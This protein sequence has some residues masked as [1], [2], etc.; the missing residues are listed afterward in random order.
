M[1]LRFLL[2]WGV[3]DEALFFARGFINVLSVMVIG[4]AYQSA[5]LNGFIKSIGDVFFVLK[6]ESFFVFCVIIPASLLAANLGAS[7]FLVFAILKCDQIL[8]C[9]VAFFKLKKLSLGKYKK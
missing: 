2:F 1:A 5:S 7:P 4:T 9:P 3:K 6:T 8:K